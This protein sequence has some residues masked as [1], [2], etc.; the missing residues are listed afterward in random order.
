MNRK[1]N[2]ISLI[3][4][5]A[6][7]CAGM[8]LLLLFNRF[9]MMSFPLGARMPLMIITYYLPAAMPIILAVVN[10]EKLSDFGFK[11][12]KIGLQILIGLG[13]GIAMSAVFTLIP[14]LIGLGNY[15]DNG[16]RYKYLWQFIFEFI[17]LTLGVGA[18][19]EFIF[20]GF[21][22]TRFKNI[23]GKEYLAVIL[24]SVLFGLFHISGGSI[25]QILITGL[26]GAL[27]CTFRLKIKNCSTLSLIIMHGVYDGLI[28]VMA[29][30]LLK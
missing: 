30:L 7:V 29:S 27:W 9:A 19:E 5:I 15:V 18:V 25:I 12:E 23:F 11:K 13:L 6:G 4:G 24:S 16:M 2:I 22:Y 1:K 10:K 17:Y 28:T 3:I 14:H 20:R 26:L 8:A 21:F